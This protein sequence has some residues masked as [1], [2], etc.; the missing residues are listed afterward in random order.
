[1]AR[2]PEPG[3]A[4][5]D[6]HIVCWLYAGLPGLLSGPAADV[7]ERS[8]LFVSPIIELELQLLYEIGRILKGPD[9][10]FRTLSREIGLEVEPADFRRVVAA[11]RELT[12]TRDPFDRLIVAQAALAGAEL[13]TKDALIRK[14]CTFA[15][16]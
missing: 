16:W 8:R 14:H 1:M 6:T 4:H 13:V 2:A 12:W 11:A 3:L 10:V 7:I 15:V 5:L 9:A